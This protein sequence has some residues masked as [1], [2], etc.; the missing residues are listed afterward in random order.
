MF[1]FVRSALLYT[2][3]SIRHQARFLQK[4]IMFPQSLNITFL[5]QGSIWKWNKISIQFHRDLYLS[6][7]IYT[8]LKAVFYFKDTNRRFKFGTWIYVWVGITWGRIDSLILGKTKKSQSSANEPSKNW[9]Y[10]SSSFTRS[11]SEMNHVV[12]KK[13]NLSLAIRQYKTDWRSL[14]EIIDSSILSEI[15]SYVSNCLPCNGETLQLR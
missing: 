2:V 15:L 6:K 9:S 13:K 8:S 14:F 10:T 4:T 5:V 3:T 1:S 7:V 11:I 12:M